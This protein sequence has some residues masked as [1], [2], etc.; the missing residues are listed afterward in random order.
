MSWIRALETFCKHVSATT[1]PSIKPYHDKVTRLQGGKPASFGEKDIKACQAKDLQTSLTTGQKLSKPIETLARAKLRYTLPDLETGTPA[2]WAKAT[3]ALVKHGP[4]S[5]QYTKA[6][7]AYLKMLKLIDKWLADDIKTVQS[8][9]PL[10]E[11][12]AKSSQQEAKLAKALDKLFAECVKTP[13]LAKSKSTFAQLQKDSADYAKV[14]AQLDQSAA[15]IR[16]TC[17]TELAAIQKLKAANLTWIRA[18]EKRPPQDE[19]TMKKNEKAKTP[20]F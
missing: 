11:N 5:P 14:A 9:I 4:K 3:I 19:K 6:F 2:L 20:S 16:A 10:A 18:C 1:V 7:Q 17:K 15:T 12:L 8:A 13:S